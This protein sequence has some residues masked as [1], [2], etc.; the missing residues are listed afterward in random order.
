[1][2]TAASSRSKARIHLVLVGVWVAAVENADA[3]HCEEL[4]SREEKC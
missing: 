3:F 4:E 2:A 1:M